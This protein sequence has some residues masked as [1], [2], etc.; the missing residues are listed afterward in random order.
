MLNVLQKLKSPE[1]RPK[2]P[3]NKPDIKSLIK[4]YVDLDDKVSK[5]LSKYYIIGNL[6]K[7]FLG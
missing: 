3:E 1:N 7:Y 2:S 5:I 6:K 4:T